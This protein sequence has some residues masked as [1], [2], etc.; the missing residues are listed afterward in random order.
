MLALLM[1]MVLTGLGAVL[2]S[3]TIGQSRVIRHDQNFTQALPSADAA[4]SRGLFML[5]NGAAGSLPS[6]GSPALLTQGGQSAD[7]YA[8]AQTSATAP[9]SYLLSA[10]TRTLQRHLQAVAYQSARF[11]GGAFA[12]KGV[13]MRG[14]NSSDSYNSSTGTLTKT[15][16]GA[17]GSN[18]SVT[19]NGNATTDSVTLWNWTQNPSPARCSGGPC[20]TYTTVAN[21]FDISSADATQFISA[22]LAACSSAPAFTTSATS[23]HALPSGTSCAS[24]LNLDVDTTVTGP[25]VI[26]VSGNVT[27]GHHLNINYS[28]SVIPVPAN[29]QIYML[30]STYDMANHTAIAAAIYAPLAT[31]NGGAQSVVYGSLVCGTISNVG[32]W[33]FHYDDALATIGMGDFRI[34]NYREG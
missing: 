8:T 29:L 19:L 12:D 26:Y 10:T 25:T 21:A 23:T 7:W 34:R 18:G 31:C 4:I 22:Q 14:G 20:P 17:I 1:T 11:T 33:T 27:M 13:V 30:G 2:L 28:S 5:N 9:T 3:T 6:S 16:H 15:G 32:G 24:S